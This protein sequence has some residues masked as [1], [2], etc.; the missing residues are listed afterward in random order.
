MVDP[1]EEKSVVRDDL[2]KDM[3]SNISN[4]RREHVRVAHISP[5]RIEFNH[6]GS[7]EP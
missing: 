5:S 1:G 6:E 7:Q 4:T 3:N 2:V